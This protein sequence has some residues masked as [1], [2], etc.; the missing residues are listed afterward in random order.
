M[1]LTEKEAREKRCCQAFEPNKET[2]QRG[3]NSFSPLYDAM[4]F[5][6][7]VASGCMAW[8]WYH[9]TYRKQDA[10]IMCG[11]GGREKDVRKGFC[12]LAGRV[13]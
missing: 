3:T 4:T 9:W 8:R 1:L 10:C 6:K 11:E 12:G 2:K 5:K 13:E 7:C